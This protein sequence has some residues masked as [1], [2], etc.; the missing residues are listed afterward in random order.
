VPKGR[1]H[2]RIPLDPLPRP[3]P[4]PCSKH[5]PHPPMPAWVAQPDT[6]L[7][8]IAATRSLPPILH[9]AAYLTYPSAS[10]F[11]HL[12]GIIVPGRRGLKLSLRDWPA[13]DTSRLTSESTLLPLPSSP[14]PSP[15]PFRSGPAVGAIA[16]LRRWCDDLAA[17]K[18][19]G[20]TDWPPCTLPPPL[21]HHQ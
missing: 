5:P 21:R 8:P 14:S 20:W 18:A 16:H 3:S 17:A 10:T 19:E 2:R 1:S 6:S 4:R 15:S 9:R 13:C 7:K 12:K 11:S